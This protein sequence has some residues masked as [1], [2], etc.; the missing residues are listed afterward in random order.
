M[1]LPWFFKYQYAAI[2]LVTIALTKVSCFHFNFSTFQE[3]ESDIW[4]HKNSN[5]FFDAIQVTP[6]IGGPIHNYAGR[7]FYTKPYQLW[8]QNQIASFNTTF[9]LRITPR[10]SPG[11]EG[12]AFILT[13]D[14]TLPEN[15]DG[16]WLGIVN[17]T[18]NGTL[19][20]GILAVEFDTRHSFTEDG[21]DNHLGINI[22]SINS[23]QEVSLI[24]AG[25]NLSS[26][27]DV[28]FRIQ[29]INDIISVFGATNG[30][31]EESMETLLVTP[32]LNL[33]SFLQQEVYF[34]FSASTS[35]YTQQNC[36]RSW[37]LS[38]D[39]IRD[40]DKSLLWVY[41]TVP[42]VIVFVIIGGLVIFFLRRK[43]SGHVE[44]PED[45][46]QRI[47]DQIQYSSM[48][49]KKFRLKEITKA[50]GGFSP[51]NKLGQGGFGTVYKG[52]LEN[53][54]VA[55]KRVSK[56]SRQG[57][58]EFVAEVTTIGSLHHRN[59]VK[60]TG[61]C[62]ENREF[63]LVYEFMPNGSLDK[64]LFGDFF[65]GNCGLEGGYSLTLNWE[66]RHRVIHGVAQALDYLHNGCEKR[67]LHRDVKASNIM[68]DSDYNAKLGDF[69]L[70]RTI[71]KRNE[72]HHS[73]KE[74]AGT[75]GYMAP[76]TFLTGRATVETDVYAFGV[77]VLE[78]VCGK[79]PG[80]VYAQDDYK[81]SI[82]YWVWDLH[83]KGKVVRGVDGRLKKEEI[84]EEEVECVLVLGL[85]CCHPNPHQRPSMRT[86]LQVLNGEAP[87]PEVAKER[88]V[89]MWPAMP[90]SFKDAKDS[91][92]IQ[93]TLLT[94]IIGR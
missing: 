76:E 56:N 77:L 14:K 32:P 80:N 61:W 94:E 39:D 34:G 90:P 43:K 20:A 38:G 65:F 62:Y 8:N 51:Q 13:S 31:S 63:L 36:V 84:K 30:T 23:I 58:Q 17:A 46:F 10:T 35:N 83:G 2:V 48:A 59:L 42:T 70:A 73:T 41:V 66:T 53:K 47:E 18:S 33:S 87:P 26:G 57:K 11:G 89:F 22:N 21:P 4:L 6:D 81:N 37:E 68:L 92:L 9:V 45:A 28:K 16:E 69:G 29:Y 64:Y 49:P 74:I 91:S 5:I 93:G 24:D 75:P 86:V 54:E 44:G 55:V 71:E 1:K 50:T 88:P 78:V 85:A 7:A 25:I 82:V 60:L 72:T 12:L 19:Q 52:L 79:R 15:S 40:N 67:V 27:K 3:D